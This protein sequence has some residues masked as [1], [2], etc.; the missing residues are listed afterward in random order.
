[1][2]TQNMQKHTQ[3]MDGNEAAASVAYRL[4]EVS[5]IYPITPSTPMGEL[6]DQWS[7]EGRHNIWG[8][9][10]EVI[11]LQSEGGASGTLH[12][13]L[14]AGALATTY[15]S[16]QGLLLMLPNMYKI[17]G[18]LTP[19]VMHVA[20]RALA[21][22][23]L[24]I[25]GDHNDVMTARSTGFAM[26]CSASVQEAHDLALIA[27]AATLEARIPFLHFFEGFR[28]SHELNKIIPLDDATLQAMIDENLILEHRKRALN[29][30]H[31]CVRGTA[32]NP[33]VYF[34]GRETVNPFYANLPS[35][36]EKNMEKFAS[37]T[38]RTY[39]PMHYYGS[40]DADRVIV[41]M[42][43][44]SKV[45]E[46]TVAYLQ[47]QGEKVGVLQIV[48]Y[49]PF[50]TKHFFDA[51]PK[52]TKAI[53]VLDRVKEPGS[54][55]E[56]L[57]Q[58]VITAISEGYAKDKSIFAH[59][60]MPHIIGGRYGLSSKEFTPA[61][62]KA[63][64]AELTKQQN[65]KNHF[66][67][68][69]N[70]DVSNSSLDYD[71]DFVLEADD[72]VRAV[73][74][75]L[76]ADGTVGANKNTIKIIGEETDNYIQGYFVYDSKKSG[77]RTVSHLRF[78]A[79][80][81][82]SPY[83][84]QKANFIGCH[85]FNFLESID[86]L[87]YATE[88]TRFLLNSPYSAEEVWEHLPRSVQ[89][90]II[91]KKIKFYVIDAYKVANQAGIGSRINTVMQ[92]CFFA[93][94]N[95]LPVEAA[96]Q[97]IKETITKT[98]KRKGEEIVNKNFA[99][100]DHALANL[101]E[102]AVPGSVSAQAHDMPEAV[103]SKAPEFVR[104]VLAQIMRGRGD[105]IPV[106]AMPIDGTYPTATTKWE[107]RNISQLVPK[108][109]EKLCIQCG[110]C[111]F[112]CPH[113]VIRAKHMPK[114][115]LANAPK[116][117]ITAKARFG[118]KG[119]GENEEQFRLQVYLEDCTGCNLCNAICPG[120]SK[121]TPNAKSI[122]LTDK[123]ALMESE[124]KNIDFFETLSFNDSVS[125]VTANIRDVQ[126]LRP[127][128]EFSSAC[129]GCGETPY[130]KLISQL[131]GERMVVAN[132]TG[133]SSIYGANLPTTPWSTNDKGCGPAWANSLFE[134]NAEFGLGF[135][136]AYDKL[137]QYAL[138]LAAECRDVLGDELVNNITAEAARGNTEE[139]IAKQ[140]QYV[141]DVKRKLEA[142]GKNKLS[143]KAA[144]LAVIADYLMTHSVWLVGGDGWAYDID[145]GGLDHVLA[146]GKKVN[147]LVLDTEVYS[148]TGGQS[149]KATPRSA[150][151]KFAMGGKSLPRKNLG[152]IAMTYGN[153]YVAQVAL[154]ANPA[155]ALK[156]IKEAESY[157][158]TAIVI[159]YSHCIAQGYDLSRAI[160]QQKLAVKSG[161]W[162]LYRFDPRRAE[163]NLNPLQLDSQAPSVPV[164]QY[165]YNEMRFK[166]LVK[167]SPE[168]AAMLLK[169]L[170]ADVNKQW[171]LL[172]KQAQTV[173]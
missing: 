85:Q 57:Y 154:A 125:D 14:Q 148:N 167:T 23:A 91:N 71:H 137:Q 129:A 16:S 117:F 45:L 157:P 92:T 12:G 46:K 32:Q 146:C 101:H 77:S 60:A 115:A 52:T 131:F 74:Y 53:A 128:F 145:F 44:A 38:G 7:S 97:K 29:P 98:Y 21:A 162:P 140:R 37:L 66:T 48:L 75:G 82:Y 173:K 121:T 5:A 136:V 62:A 31:P 63:I 93:I 105:D 163:Q 116:D 24:S 20:S 108:W 17:A 160:E 79:N 69:I 15:T 109:D 13:L 30:A 43:S 3:I 164:E 127:L 100:V 27:H 67:I 99:A 122:M 135:R 120:V 87:E 152:A 72:V 141:A 86:V 83:L 155:H 104:T 139:A 6:A 68:G 40:K 107:K 64:F 90:T 9:V 161:F 102:V 119:E 123:T 8:M 50:S 94:A 142:A 95:I 59:G 132:A 1:M 166:S 18:E 76:G 149:S 118:A 26:L 58:D 134:D 22:Q 170:Q 168:R 106:S 84:V 11:E 126:F 51:L 61:M 49:R 47:K 169:E 78:G 65:A 88:G 147:I 33:D 28:V 133:C 80:P 39:A 81:I 41:V 112:I 143:P 110:L 153:V 96:L 144:H 138:G 4:T 34:Q 151:A 172:E 55:G 111:S 2:N 165:A 114:S 89:Q 10:P 56:P 171:Q 36:V 113:S 150:I 103:S 25:F 35:I 124:R 130:L 156:A 70:D 73:F 158:G 42:G 19:L 159:A 54:L